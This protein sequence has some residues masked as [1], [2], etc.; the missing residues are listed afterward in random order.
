[1]D[2]EKLIKVLTYEDIKKLL[3]ETLDITS[4]TNNAGKP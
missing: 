4:T 3:S 1:M 2:R